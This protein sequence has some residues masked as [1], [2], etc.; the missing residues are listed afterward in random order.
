MKN[1]FCSFLFFLGSILFAEG[2]RPIG[3]FESPDSFKQIWQTKR[4]VWAASVHKAEQ[5][6]FNVSQ[7]KFSLKVQISGKKKDSWPYLEY[8]FPENDNDLSKFTKMHLSIF[9]PGTE[10]QKIGG[11]FVTR[12][13]DDKDKQIRIWF[14]IIAKPGKNNI[15][16]SMKH[17]EGTIHK[18]G[19]GKGIGDFSYVDKVQFFIDRP[20]KDFELYFDD[21]Y[22]GDK[23]EVK[24]P[25]QTE[26]QPV[27]AHHFTGDWN[28][29]PS[30]VMNRTNQ[31][32]PGN[33][34]VKVK[35]AYDDQNLY[36]Q[37]ASPG[38]KNKNSR[39]LRRV[40]P[41]VYNSG[42]S[43]EI[44]LQN[45]QETPDVYYQ[46][47][48]NSY[49]DRY[50]NRITSVM[51]NPGWDRNWK[52][53][54]IREKDGSWNATVSL[55]WHI[56]S[57]AKKTKPKFRINIFR[58]KSMDDKN[59]SGSLA[60]S[61][62]YAGY[63]D[64]T[65]FVS[66][67]T[68]VPGYQ[69]YYAVTDSFSVNHPGLGKNEST[70]EIS[71]YQSGNLELEII[72]HK[73]EIIHKSTQNIKK[74]HNV[75]TLPFLVAAP[76]KQHL[77][78]YVKNGNQVISESQINFELPAPLTVE[79][80]EPYYRNTIYQGKVPEK[81]TGNIRVSMLEKT[82]KNS[83]NHVSLQDS[84]GTILEQL[85]LPCNQRIIPFAFHSKK[86]KF[87]T[88]KIHAYIS[89][90][91]IGKTGQTEAILKYLPAKPE[92]VYIERD[93]FLN[94]NGKK[95]FPFMLYP[96]I[97]I[98]DLP[99]LK[100][101]GFNTF[102]CF[103]PYKADSKWTLE[104]M[105]S[106]AKLGLFTL[107]LNSH[108]ICNN[109]TTK[110]PDYA[111]K[112]IPALIKKYSREKNVLSYGMLDEPN[113]YLFGYDEGYAKFYQ[114]MVDLDPYRPVHIVENGEG[115]IPAVHQEFGDIFEFDFYP[116]YKKNG[117]CV[118][119]LNT[120][121][122]KVRL[123]KSQLK[124][125]KCIT[126]AFQ[127]YDRIRTWDKFEQGR[128]ANYIENRCLFWSA[129]AE[130]ARG[131]SFW[132]F[133]DASVGCLGT[134]PEWLGITRAV[135]EFN[136]MLPVVFAPE[137]KEKI[138]ISGTGTDFIH[139]T[140]RKKNGY[141]YIIAAYSGEKKTDLTFKG[142]FLETIKNLKVLGENRNISI[143]R[144]TFSDSFDRYGVH[145]Y[146]NDPNPPEIRSIAQN[147]KDCK[148]YETAI[149]KRNQGNLLHQLY[150]NKKGAVRIN[151]FDSKGKEVKGSIYSGQIYYTV[152]GLR[153]HAFYYPANRG[154]VTF[155]FA[156][157]EPVRINKIVIKGE[158]N[159]SR[160]TVIGESALEILVNN[161]WQKAD[162]IKNNT[163]TEIVFS[164]P[165]ANVSGFRFSVDKVTSKGTV[166][167][168][169]VEAWL[170]K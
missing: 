8:R 164:F 121:P 89:H 138:S 43:I 90:S 79:I 127:G 41:A 70:V 159:N 86:L 146:T 60:Y 140:V 76:E 122:L 139:A 23:P 14:N 88:F 31:G 62:T 77:T 66:L 82:M 29:I 155:N 99:M 71:A 110:I 67:E 166:F 68:E 128:I 93:G 72:D 156:L 147:I 148:A 158:E 10:N 101:A 54:V 17:K 5:S 25:V 13:A 38:V 91:E 83:K 11:F 61:P 12:G 119:P 39:A 105:D 118:R 151:A 65:K 145:L 48:I 168:D 170:T 133:N 107:P 57:F 141:Y 87:G 115:H 130:G 169:E 32:L 24:T 7:G 142:T 124:P 51:Q 103:A 116:G 36:F 47:V 69:K 28:K 108:H 33:D 63:H 131:F 3:D 154:K 52:T 117:L 160:K 123:L 4:G 163:K 157:T 153:R 150:T 98:S 21:I 53:D 97:D 40:S 64:L 161:V 111:H 2:Y 84:N 20:R 42:E 106:A 35:V 81:I 37:F 73:K 9:N 109:R 135:Q 80:K 114:N 59:V 49:G 112:L 136:T 55:P 58:N 137:A 104:F 149:Q 15:V 46:F 1:L 6:E 92:M 18:G 129:Y 26:I 100:D 162:I 44:F 30:F 132:A 75:L 45:D 95:F 152:D 134:R 94:V 56:F 85:T 144:G 27:K 16:V 143:N 22:F 113:A 34:H 120:I 19:R 126:V 50:D 167:I 125:G 102:M 96:N 165:A 74:G 78:L